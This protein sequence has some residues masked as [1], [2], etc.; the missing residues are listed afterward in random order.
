[1]TRK[2]ITLTTLAAFATVLFCSSS[3]P[4]VALS[5][6]DDAVPRVNARDQESDQ[7]DS[8]PHLP[9]S[10]D[11]EAAPQGLSPAGCYG[12][13]D[14]AHRSEHY[15]SVHGRTRCT[16]PVPELGVTTTLQK[17]GWVYWENMMSDMSSNTG[18]TTSHDAHPHWDCRGWGDQTYRGASSHYSIEPSGTYTVDTG[19]VE[20][21]FFC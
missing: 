9:L 2:R 14:Y 1:M 4:A 17:L 8:L 13:T 12:Q 5:S 15:M 10:S 21:R 18:A 16:T 20:G 3:L 7:P 6:A 19:G 11:D